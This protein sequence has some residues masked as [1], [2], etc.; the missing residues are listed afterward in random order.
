MTADDGL[1]GGIPGDPG[2]SPATGDA[3][4]D[5]PDAAGV[6]MVGGTRMDPARRRWMLEHRIANPGD[7]PV[8]R[9]APGARPGPDQSDLSAPGRVA[10]VQGQVYLVGV[11]LVAQLWLITTALF[12]LLSGRPQSLWG[13]TIASAVGFALALVVVFWP[14]RR[15][16]GR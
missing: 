11:I 2:Q 9:L 8:A 16:R 10:I 7:P 14:R 6:L 13:I 3:P 15:L 12:E 1:P 4:D 5:A